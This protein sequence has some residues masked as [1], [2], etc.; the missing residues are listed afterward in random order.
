MLQ[1]SWVLW[2]F[3]DLWF[4]KEITTEHYEQVEILDHSYDIQS[5]GTHV[6]SDNEQEMEVMIKHEPKTQKFTHRKFVDTA[7]HGKKKLTRTLKRKPRRQ[8]TQTNVQQEMYSK[9][10][11][12]SR[13]LEVQRMM[14]KDS[15][16]KKDDCDTYGEYIASTLRKHD[17]KTQCMIKQAIN[18]ILFEQEMNKYEN[19]LDTD[20]VA[21]I[22]DAS[23]D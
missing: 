2:S 1:Y 13:I 3:D 6:A 7:S 5:D 8:N 14:K 18:N 21:E 23:D 15:L 16:I 10:Y 11:V 12:D 20:I 4:Q 19:P 22:L 17:N 9:V